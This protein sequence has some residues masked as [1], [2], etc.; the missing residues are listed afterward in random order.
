[1]IEKTYNIYMMSLVTFAEARNNL[2]FMSMG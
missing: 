1:M 2:I